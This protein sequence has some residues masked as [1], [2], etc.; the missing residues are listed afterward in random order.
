[1]H[2]EETWDL[3]RFEEICAK[4]RWINEPTDSADAKSFF[5]LKEKDEIVGC[6]YT[7]KVFPKA[8]I[9]GGLF[10]KKDYRGKGY[11]FFLANSLIAVLKNNGCRL[12][13]IGVHLDNTAGVRFWRKMGF[14]SLLTVDPIFLKKL[15]LHVLSPFPLPPRRSLIMFRLG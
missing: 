1:M 6:G 4:S 8:G 7:R 12:F 10:I 9:L 11:G 3:E 2:L 5:F 14:S 15:H 13:L